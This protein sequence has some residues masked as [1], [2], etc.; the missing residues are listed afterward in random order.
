[1]NLF[2]P[3]AISLIFLS[4]LDLAP[5]YQPPQEVLPPP[6]M[7]SLTFVFDKTG[8]MNDDLSQVR[9]G[10]RGIFEMVM[11]QRKKFIHNYVLVTF[12]DPG[13]SPGVAGH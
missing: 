6:G 11:K 4:L 5:C 12:H 8:S 7:S 13:R 1:M 10:A 2:G 3:S 9:Q